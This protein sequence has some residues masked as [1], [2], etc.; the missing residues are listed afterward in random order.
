MTE[1]YKLNFDSGE[2]KEKIKSRNF[3]FNLQKN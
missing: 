2:K 1:Y 3:T